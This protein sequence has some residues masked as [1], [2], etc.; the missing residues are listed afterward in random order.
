LLLPVHRLWRECDPHRISQGESRP[1]SS[2]WR[3]IMRSGR[4]AS[5]PS[6]RILRCWLGTPGESDSPYQAEESLF[7]ILIVTSSRSALEAICVT[8]TVSKGQSSVTCSSRGAAT[9]VRSHRRVGR[10]LLRKVK[11]SVEASPVD[12]ERPGLQNENNTTATS[13]ICCLRTLVYI[14]HPHCK[15]CII[16]G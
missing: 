3:R 5:R 16:Y 8:G 15:L 14:L 4:L 13:R 2:Q 7:R 6:H 9:L 1:T 11:C 10:L 12:S